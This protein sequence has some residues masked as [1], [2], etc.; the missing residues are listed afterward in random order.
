MVNAGNGQII[1]FAQ[2]KGSHHDFSLFKDSCKGIVT[3]IKIKADSGYQGICAIHENSEIPFKQ[4]KKYPLSKEKKL[5]NKTLASERIYIEH[6]NRRIKRFKILSHRYRNKRR[7][8]A[9]RV[10]LKCR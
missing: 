7:K 4:S 3:K 1:S 8:H 9:I 2:T 5:A 6:V 10:A